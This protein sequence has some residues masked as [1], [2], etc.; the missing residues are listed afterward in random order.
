MCRL[1]H[2]SKLHLVRSGESSFAQNYPFCEKTEFIW[3]EVVRASFLK[4]YYLA[5]T[6][7]KLVIWVVLVDRWGVVRG[8]SHYA[9]IWSQVVRSGESNFFVSTHFDPNDTLGNAELKLLFGEE[10]RLV[11][12]SN[13]TTVPG[14]LILQYSTGTLIWLRCR[15]SQPENPSKKYPPAN[16]S[17]MD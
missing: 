15:K 2:I 3:W 10:S 17:K 11:V 13:V 8:K 7:L 9:P 1:D 5:E 6:P 16:C 4:T 12:I 14:L